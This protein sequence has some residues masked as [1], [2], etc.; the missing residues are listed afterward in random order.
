MS[1]SAPPLPRASLALLSRS[2]GDQLR[3]RNRGRQ[4]RR[5]CGSLACAGPKRTCCDEGRL[6]AA[7]AHTLL[8]IAAVPVCHLRQGIWICIAGSACDLGRGAD[9]ARAVW[10]VAVHRYRS[11][12]VLLAKRQ[13]TLTPRLGPGRAR[14]R[15]HDRHE[16]GDGCH[17]GSS[18]S[19]WLAL[20]HRASELDVLFFVVTTGMSW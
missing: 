5:A 20:D 16:S 15:A 1:G 18:G 2:K 17:V 12:S 13:R 4:R 6:R 7:A 19:D 10:R 8:G 9:K 11:G 3:Y 14:L